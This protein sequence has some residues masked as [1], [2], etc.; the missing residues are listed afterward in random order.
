[1]TPDFMDVA[2]VGGGLSGLTTAALL[3]RGSRG[4]RGS[5]SSRGSRRGLRV[6]VLE[7]STSLGGRASTQLRDGFAFNEGA[8][9]LYVGGAAARVLRSLGARWSGRA[10]SGPRVAV[11]G[12]R[13]CAL[14]TNV[15]ALLRT[16]LL[17]WSA[18][19]QGARLLARLGA[20]DTGA[21]AGTSVESWLA[22][23]TTDPVLRATLEAFVRL[24]TYANAPA[25]LSAAAAI[26]QLRLGQR[27]GVMYV[28]GGWGTLV[29]SVSGI[30]RAAGAEVRTGSK[31]T[32]AEPVDDGSP[33]KWRVHVDGGSAIAC[34]ALVL[35]TGPLSARS[36]LGSDALAAWSHRATPLKVACLDVALSRLPQEKTTFALG[37]DR[38][39]HLSV[40]SHVARVAPPGA[41]LVHTMKYLPVDEA[42]DPERDEAELEA[43]LDQLQP[44]WRAVLVERRWMPAMVASHALVEA[45][46]GGLLARPGPAIPDAPFAFVVGDWVGPEGMLLDASMA[47][48][49]LVASHV[50]TTLGES[51]G[52]TG[53]AAG[54]AGAQRI[55]SVA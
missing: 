43:W 32:C 47:S 19:A 12:D 4:S 10:P 22:E 8:H 39:L 30:A 36:I 20:I 52:G 24:A 40:H 13:S 15:G 1:M 29:E 48:A 3:S 9:A 2:V 25:R 28:D 33:V 14:P 45:S 35:A 53:E 17:P 46:R 11:L 49:E 44:G 42:S 27:P 37:I 16:S 5:Q 23:R 54:A 50:G 34:G 26:A 55:A 21:L 31:V 6:V 38:P 7:R 41:A 51:A 18:K